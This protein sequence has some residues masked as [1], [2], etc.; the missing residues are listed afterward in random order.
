MIVL[1]VRVST[2]SSQGLD[3]FIQFSVSHLYINSGVAYSQIWDGCGC[4][5]QK[6]QFFPGVTYPMIC[7]FL[8]EPLLQKNGMAAILNLKFT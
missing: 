4:S 5:R 3:I 2:V 6:R 7:S 1:S 8:I